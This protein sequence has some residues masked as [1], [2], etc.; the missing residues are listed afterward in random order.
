MTDHKFTTECKLCIVMIIGFIV[1]II[2]TI[3]KWFQEKFHR[4]RKNNKIENNENTETLENIEV[5]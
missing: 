5:D 3:R 2:V 4:K 1:D